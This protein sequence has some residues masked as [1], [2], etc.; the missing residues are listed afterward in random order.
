M[1]TLDRGSTAAEPFSDS[2]SATGKSVP[3]AR[4]EVSS[5][6]APIFVDVTGRR[7]LVLRSLG[8]LLAA[9]TL[10]A[11]LAIPLSIVSP[12]GFG[13]GARAAETNPM[14]VE[15]L[16]YIDQNCDGLRSADEGV[17]R[18]AHVE[19]VRDG[20]GP[21]AATQTSETGRFSF[22]GVESEF[23]YDLRVHRATDSERAAGFDT[24]PITPRT[25]GASDAALPLMVPDGGCYPSNLDVG[26]EMDPSG[27][28]S[29]DPNAI[30]HQ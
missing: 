24:Y 1:K 2:P 7:S 14:R 11:L 12:Q 13:A 27:A 4:A 5:S 16:V 18:L 26:P 25:L 8:L 19:L 28:D 15:G 10:V 22:A 17:G 23:G 29:T 9:A 6:R 20:H 21:V 30:D 3:P